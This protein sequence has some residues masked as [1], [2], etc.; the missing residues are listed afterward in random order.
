MISQQEGGR[1]CRSARPH[2]RYALRRRLSR[3][4]GEG[5]SR[6]K[7]MKSC[8]RALTVLLV[9]PPLL[10]ALPLSCTRGGGSP[11]D[12]SRLKVITTLFPLY[13]FARNVAGDKARVTLLLPPGMEP[14][15]FEPK[16]GDMLKVMSADLLVY[17]G[18]SMEP[19]VEGILKG[20]ENKNLLIVD[21]STGINLVEQREA[22]DKDDHGHGHGKA[23]P[24]VWL[25]LSKAE[26]M[27]DNI[28]EGLVTKDPTNREYYKG[29][30]EAYKV[31]KREMDEKYR[32]TLLTCK[33]RMFVHGGHFAFGY[34]ANR[35]NLHYISA[36]RGSPDA[37]PT[38]KRLIELKN[39]LKRFN[40]HYVFYEELITPRVAEII[41]RETGAALLKL[42]GAHNVTREELEKGIT[43]LS[44]M[45][46]N[47]NNLMVGLECQ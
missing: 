24:H 26:K 2:K 4:G 43:F 14:H 17:S 8:L 20:V 25:D 44:I 9:C 40:L 30:A 35:Y 15:S 13:D 38:P 29:N 16:P 11:A 27:V 31:R 41:S 36:Y 46:N 1:A 5:I 39:V 6:R 22:T 18:K 19:W 37:E 45:E 12:S 23:D 7:T 21:S 47:L 10:W 34:L 3:L 42:H 33:N 28:L 32:T